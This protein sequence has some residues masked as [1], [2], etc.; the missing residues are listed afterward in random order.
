MSANYNISIILCYCVHIF[1]RCISTFFV[2]IFL[3]ICFEK[4]K[5]FLWWCV[6]IWIL[7]SLDSITARKLAL[8]RERN[9]HQFDYD[10]CRLVSLQQCTVVYIKITKLKKIIL[11]YESINTTTRNWTP[12][13]KYLSLFCCKSWS[14]ACYSEQC[15][16]RLNEYWFFLNEWY[17]CTCTRI[18]VSC[19]MSFFYTQGVKKSSALKFITK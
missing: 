7:P 14:A 13:I 15:V 17:H 5:N 3:F 10:T 2:L 16:Q 6:I 1:N 12:L 18:V 19:L 11:S 4:N 9:T 8:E